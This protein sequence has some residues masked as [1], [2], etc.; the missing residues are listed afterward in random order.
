MIDALFVVTFFNDHAAVTKRQQGVTLHELA[1]RI[2]KTSAPSKAALPWVKLATFGDVRSS[3]GSLRHNSNLLWVTGIEIDCDAEDYSVDDAIEV[4]EKAGIEA[5]IYTSPSHMRDGHGHRWRALIPFIEPHSPEERDHFVNRVAGLFR[6]GNATIIAPE[7][8]TSSQA[9]YY[10]AVNDNPAH[11]VR[12]IEG[13]RLDHF[14]FDK[15]DL[16]A[17]GKPN[18]FDDGRPHT[19]GQPEADIDDIL[20][21]LAAIPN[22]W[23]DWPRWN[24][25]MLALF[26][27]CGGS[28]EGREA[29]RMWS[30]RNPDFDTAEFERMWKDMGR[31]PPTRSGFG[32]LVYQARRA[33]KHFVLPSLIRLDAAREAGLVDL[34][35]R[36]PPDP[37]SGQGTCEYC[38]VTITRNFVT[39][40]RPARFCSHRCRQAAYRVTKFD[41]PNRDEIRHA[42]PSVTKFDGAAENLTNG[43]DDAADDGPPTPAENLADP[44]MLRDLEAALKAI[45]EPDQ[46]HPLDR[47]RIAQALW[48]ATDGAEAGFELLDRW[49]ALS[50]EYNPEQS[51]QIWAE[52][53]RNPPLSRGAAGI[54]H[55]AQIRTGGT[56][57]RPSLRPAREA[58]VDDLSSNRH[59]FDPG[60]GE[61]RPEPGKGGEGGGDG[62]GG[63]GGEL[64]PPIGDEPGPGQGGGSEPPPPGEGG[65]DEPPP[66]DDDDEGIKDEFTQADKE[67]IERQRKLLAEATRAALRSLNGRLSEA[68]HVWVGQWRSDH[69][70]K[71]RREVLDRFTFADFRKKYLNRSVK[72]FEIDANGKPRVNRQN[73]AEWWLRHP[74]RREYND[75][76]F[77]RRA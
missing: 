30:S 60:P 1:D 40:G 45:G 41:E 55:A 67:E 5:I 43:S 17:L 7:S 27:S 23:V 70:F 25:L 32:T 52:I 14:T 47:D 54:F 58:G 29:A 2:A 33:D 57:V 19:P 16:G 73:L 9:Y 37:G 20:A 11:R 66:E 15:L 44:A 64:P 6:V 72:I 49:L 28:D 76:V 13:L 18:G 46:L 4:F 35:S 3:Q 63:H 65:D 8:W 71:I 42:A 22:D 61:P 53:S 38:G 74:K 48:Y 59:D 12:V 21:T 10:G 56:F 75:V 24:A 31:S 34:E 69:T 62:G 26:A 68:G 39:R 51:A 50:T 36:A 77:D